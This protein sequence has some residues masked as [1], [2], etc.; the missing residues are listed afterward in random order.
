[1]TG[2]QSLGLDCVARERL[3]DGGGTKGSGPSIG[4]LEN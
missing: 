2:L 3:W 4:V 1:M